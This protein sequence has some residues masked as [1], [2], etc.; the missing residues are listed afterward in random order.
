MRYPRFIL[1]LALFGLVLNAGSYSSPPVQDEG[2]TSQY[3]KKWLEEDVV[4]II[5]EE[6]KATFKALQNDE[7]R[8]AFIEQFWLRRNPD[9]RSSTNAFKEEH[10]R[11][12][13]YAN[14]RFHSG[15]PGWKT[16]RGRIYIMFGPPDQKEDRPT[17][18]TY[19]RPLHEGGGRT[20]TFPFEKWWYRHIDGI[21]DDIE[22]EFVDSSF[23]GE[24]RIAMSPD[25]K[26]ALLHV[27]GAGLTL[28]EEMGLAEKRDRAYFNPGA[29]NDPNNP[30]SMFA[31]AKDSPFSRMEQ[32]FAVQRPPK[33]KFEDL[34][35]VVSTKI[36][37]NT[38]PYDMRIDYIRLSSDKVLVPISLELNNQTLEFKREN[39]LN[40]AKVHVYGIVTSLTNR[41]IAEWESPIS[42][43]FTDENF[44]YG[45]NRRSV[46]QHTVALPPGMRYKLDL[47]LKDMNSNNIGSTSLG[48]NVP[49]FEDG[50]LQS[51]T[52]ILAN[53]IS[54]APAN[55][56]QLQ[57]Y[58]IGDM[59]VVPNV[60]SE[61]IPGQNLIT[62]MQIYNMG[63]DQT[64]DKPALD[65]TFTVRNDG[66]V[67]EE[68][69]D[70]PINSEQFF[71]GPR[72][73]LLGKIPIKEG[74]A[75][76]KYTLEIKVLDRITNRT[77]TTTT[78]FKV[79][80][81]PQNLSASNP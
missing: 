45:K 52:I 63:I 61:Y 48:L 34:K 37:Y 18:G 22:I 8:E 26:D 10:Y 65:V 7:E 41:I 76:G 42:T 69:S 9:P 73:V 12:I 13:A 59:K 55:S 80:E 20:T 79:N 3:Y 28:A 71:Y 49:K 31:R 21:G 2:D 5:S 68:I 38:L 35:S 23:T 60:K 66:K 16:D 4:W 56:D 39:N 44:D 57:Q 36:M 15:I 74:F 53:S 70:S 67:V 6:E 25:E 64:S 14:E 1:F 47:V 30:Q 72:V 75:P 58:I 19:D 54:P 43:D 32:Y 27:E 46:Y 40:R 78:D 24:Y 11:R 62:Y 50:E 17:G 33:I 77:L 51:S 81:L 29:F